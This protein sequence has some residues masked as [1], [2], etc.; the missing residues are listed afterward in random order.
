MRF[1][2]SSFQIVVDSLRVDWCRPLANWELAYQKPA[3]R[4]QL[5]GK[6]TGAVPISERRVIPIHRPQPAPVVL[7]FRDRMFYG[8]LSNTLY[9][10]DDGL[11]CP[12]VGGWAEDKFRL[13]ALY[14]QLFSTG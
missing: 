14:D 8:L 9:T 12:D 11:I 5:A 6:L 1:E 7:H 13:L 4:H 3:C 2:R 10:A